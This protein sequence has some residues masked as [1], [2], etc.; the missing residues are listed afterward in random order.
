MQ[1]GSLIVELSA[2]Q[3][4]VPIANA[5]VHVFSIQTGYDQTFITDQFG[6][7]EEIR[8]LAPD[9]ALSLDENYEGVPYAT[10]DVEISLQ[11]FVTQL[12]RNVQIFALQQALLQVDLMPKERSGLP[13]ELI[14]IPT[15]SL[16]R[17]NCRGLGPAEQPVDDSFGT[18]VLA[19]PIIPQYI[20]VHLGRP[21]SNAENVTVSFKNYIKN[22]ASSEIYPT[23]PEECLRANIYCQISL[24]LNRIYTEWYIAKGYNFNITNSTAFDQAFIKGRDIFA[25]I[26]RIVDE[27]FNEYIRK[28]NTIEPFYAEY[29]DG[30][31]AN[32]PGLKQWG[33]LSLAERGFNSF[34][35]LQNYYGKNIEIVDSDRIEGVAGSFPG[36]SLRVG[37]K[38]NAVAI[39]Q[40]QL[41]R[42]AVNYPN[43]PP[44]Y[45]VDGIFG[46][47]TE[48][49]VKVFQRQ[50]NLTADG[51]A[52]KSTW[53][54][55]SSIYVA[56]KKLAEL[57]S[58]GEQT[59]PPG[60]F[61]GTQREGSRGVAVQEMQFYLM[62]ISLFTSRVPDVKIDSNFGR[63]TKAAVIAFQKLAGLTADG[64]VGRATWNALY[65]GYLD[66]LEVAAPNVPPVLPYPGTPL[67]IGSQGESVRV[68]QYYLNVINASNRNLPQLVVDG[69]YGQNTA[70]AV[71]Q[72]QG[73]NQLSVDG[74]IGRN[75]W[76]K[77]V[78][79]YNTIVTNPL[80]ANPLYYELFN[81]SYDDYTTLIYRE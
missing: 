49:A 67:R 19:Y 35:I 46:A 76:N 79:V 7:T 47:A 73:S 2:A 25:N 50:F 48:N 81:L 53:Y 44:I 30:R 72:F 14:E 43:I 39:I 23:W 5:S 10:V 34:Q 12:T 75:T 62:R 16:L 69:R 22:V 31:Q 58:E 42:I 70:S 60:T 20:T 78:E 3:Q 15:H 54:K 6:K 64:I 28:F 4:A 29:C 13:D 66:T 33:S 68:M 56:V 74:V 77:I 9:R 57:T 18:F 55:I 27:I 37:V 41:N 24:A 21:T 59:N 71:R 8:L 32:C 63:G 61:P 45:P 1:I 36:T 17:E 65:R 51:I 38:S 26:S 40:N 80:A 52:G 11:G